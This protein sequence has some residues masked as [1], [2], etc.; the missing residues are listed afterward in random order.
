MCNYIS[1]ALFPIYGW[2][3]NNSVPTVVNL[4]Q[5][6]SSAT[7]RTSLY[8]APPTYIGNQLVNSFNYTTR[9][10]EGISLDMSNAQI[11][12]QN[13]GT[14]NISITHRGNNL[15]HIGTTDAYILL[16]S[17][18]NPNVFKTPGTYLTNSSSYTL[19]STSFSKFTTLTTNQTTGITTATFGTT[20]AEV[21]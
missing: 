14:Y 8:P 12:I 2:V 6:V 9:I 16:Y 3:A 17:S 10:S 5:Y 13:P 11:I 19:D 1:D 4:L 15:G 18:T 21:V 7:V 20:T